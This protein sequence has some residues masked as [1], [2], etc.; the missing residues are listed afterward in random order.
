[1]AAALRNADLVRQTRLTGM[2][3]QLTGFFNRAHTLEML[4][5]EMRRAR[6][7]GHP[8]SVV[9]LDLDG[10][11]AINDSRGHLCGDTLITAASAAIQSALRGSDVKGRYGGDE[12][13]LILPETPT[14]GA[15]QVAEGLRRS[16]DALHIWWNGERISATASLGVTTWC[17]E[18]QEPEAVIARADAALFHA[19]QT[20]R[21]TVARSRFGE[22][23]EPLAHGHG[24]LP[25]LTV[26][27]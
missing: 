18:D 17:D 27:T 20:G 6:R 24:G 1:M 10:L 11:K 9:M 4:E 26:E 22:P 13:V 12:F 15:G 14:E 2:R 7:S 19:T 3:D 23:P 16:I 21:N 25:A 5:A 8:L